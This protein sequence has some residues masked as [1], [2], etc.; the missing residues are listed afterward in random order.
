MASRNLLS[1][2]WK[3][4]IFVSIA[5]TETSASRGVHVR[6]SF[7]F[8][9]CLFV[10]GSGFISNYINN[11]KNDQTAVIDVTK[12]E[13]QVYKSRISEW[14]FYIGEEEYRGKGLS[15]AILFRLLEVFFDEMKFEVLFTKILSDNTVALNIYK[16]FKF[17]EIKREF[18]E[19]KRE[20]IEL[21]FTK[22]D[23]SEHRRQLEN[24]A[25]CKNK[26]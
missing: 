26:K 7:L 25:C 11:Y 12:G 6:T 17:K 1:S 13:I 23:W 19:N 9:L 14:G 3:H 5:L 16:K 8:L 4:R 24:E 10:S 21:K 22:D 18:L 15:K 20:F 2:L